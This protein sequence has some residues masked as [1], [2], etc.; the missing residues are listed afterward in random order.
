[1]KI[2]AKAKTTFGSRKILSGESDFCE[3]LPL[4][5]EDAAMPLLLDFSQ[6]CCSMIVKES[7]PRR[8]FGPRVTVQQS[9]RLSSGFVWVI[10]SYHKEMKK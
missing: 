4:A 7:H 6:I 5:A 9:L 10:E 1:M 8:L 3:G 2:K